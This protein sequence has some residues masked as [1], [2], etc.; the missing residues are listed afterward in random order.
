MSSKWYTAT[1][2]TIFLS[3]LSPPSLSLLPSSIL[4]PLSPPLSLSYLSSSFP[5]LI[6]LLF[7]VLSPPPSASLSPFFSSP[8]L[9]SLSPS[10]PSSSLSPPPSSLSSPLPPSP[11]PSKSLDGAVDIGTAT[12]YGLKDRGI[13]FRVQVRGKIFTSPHRP[14]RF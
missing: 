7:L 14:N 1:V 5:L 3:L 10:P 6:L 11:P 4:S 2:R 12:A 13:G 9:S 8:P